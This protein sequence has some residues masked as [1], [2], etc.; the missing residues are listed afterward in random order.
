MRDFCYFGHIL[1]EHHTYLTS[2][3]SCHIG[4]FTTIQI[5]IF[6]TERGLDR[7]MQTSLFAWIFL[8]IECLA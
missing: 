8:R 5:N 7:L 1:A 4:R 3:F 6:L 2:P